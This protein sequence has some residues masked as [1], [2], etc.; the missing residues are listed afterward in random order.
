MA[1]KYNPPHYIAGILIDKFVF[2]ATSTANTGSHLIDKLNRKIR[3]KESNKVELKRYIFV[4]DK[5]NNNRYKYTFNVFRDDIEIGILTVKHIKRKNYDDYVFTVNNALHYT[6]NG[7]MPTISMFL[8]DFNLSLGKIIQLDVAIDHYTRNPQNDFWKVMRNPKSKVIIIRKAY[9]IGQYIPSIETISSG[10]RENRNI[11]ETTYLKQA[12][13]TSKKGLVL[14]DKLAEIMLK[15][16]E[17]EYI[18]L[19][20]FCRERNIEDLHRAEIRTSGKYI[21]QYEKK[22]GLKID[23]EFLFN[24]AALCDYFMFHLEL[25][26][27]ITDSKGR[28][29]TFIQKPYIEF[30]ETVGKGRKKEVTAISFNL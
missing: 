19:Y 6:D 21:T 15:S 25:L 18:P 16:Q 28:L 8:Y 27:K 30:K 2:S 5:D 17:K 11:F 26:V 1:K 10:T 3:E 23:L 22:R 24:D 7:C 29:N 20:H 13:G 9:K 4:K 12:D 14:Y